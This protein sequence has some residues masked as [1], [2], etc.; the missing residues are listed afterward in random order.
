[1]GQEDQTLPILALPIGSVLLPGT[2]LR[3]PV[4][5]RSDIPALLATVY[6]KD[7][8]LRPDTKTISIGCVPVNSP[9]LR[10]DGQ[11]LLDDKRGKSQEQPEDDDPNP[12]QI[13]HRRLFM[14]GTV[15]K[16]SGVQG[17]KAEDL[18]L[19]VEG[20]R[21]FRIDRFV[22]MRPFFVAEIM[23]LEEERGELSTA[24]IAILSQLILAIQLLGL[25][26]PATMKLDLLTRPS[27]D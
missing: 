26:W 18:A 5:G 7:R 12:S 15:A 9:L 3:I 1:M 24:M 6:S 20:L 14:Y 16:I 8:S 27:N 21:R 23:Y 25:E 11:Q 19:I 13:D 17:R 22:Q 10:S 4:A 2:T